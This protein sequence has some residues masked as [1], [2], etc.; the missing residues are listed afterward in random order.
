MA[1]LL[2]YG[3]VGDATDG[4]DAH[5]FCSVIRAQT[6]DL[7]LRINCAGGAVFDGLAIY[8]AIVAYPRRVTVYVDGIAASMASVIAMAAD[9]IIMSD[10]AMMMIHDP[11]TM[12]GGNS[13][14]LRADASK[15]DKVSQ[16]LAGI[17]S[18]RTGLPVSRIAAMMAAETWMTADE[19]RTAGFANRTSPGLRMAAIGN[20]AAFGF[21]HIPDQLRGQ[22]M[23][24]P[25]Q[26]PTPTPG[27]GGPA[28]V[29]QQQFAS[30]SEIR[31]IVAQARLPESVA[32]D[33][34]ERPMPVAEVRAAV[35][36]RIASSAPL[37]SN[38]APT[39]QTFANPEFQAA[40]MAD[41]LYSRMSGK[42]P[43]GAAVAMMNLTMTDMARE[44]LEGAG[45]SGVR[46]MHPNE[47]FN[48]ASFAPR[49]DFGGMHTTSDFPGLLQSAGQRFLLD[50]FVAAE[51]AIKLLS[52]VRNANDFR[53]LTVLKLSGG[54]VLEQTPEAGEI[55]R[56]GFSEGKESYSIATFA[57]I[58]AISRQALINDDLGAFTDPARAMGR[59]SAETEAQQ[60]AGLLNANAGKGATMGDAKPLFDATH[61]NLAAAGGAI[62]IA[63]ASAGRQTMR[64]QLDADG[65]TPLNATAKFLLTGP[66]KETEA[67]QFLTT[68]SATQTANVNPF[69]GKIT[70]LVDPRIAGNAW[71]LFADPAMLPVIEHAYLNGGAGPMMETR[72][73]WDVLGTEFR[74][75][76]DFGCGLVDY[77]G[78]YLNTG[79]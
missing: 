32:L 10:T 78:A 51:S 43:E 11:E 20:L 61:K 34:A 48:R 15:L 2:L 4:L 17:Y 38:F 42:R 73:G 49:A 19:A 64:A 47:V 41:A 54:G 28:I 22:T 68:L 14:A 46:R 57:K 8:E 3:I 7:A 63:T 39:A 67:E 21:R 74:V 24:V 62:T 50:M 25:A 37:I 66:A 31:A 36:D 72:Q 9:E 1:E 59:A 58:F 27:P 44:M 35:I 70:P 52:R 26:T 45:V 29:P 30:V 76:L 60:F 75:V 55:T 33:L 65:V 16:Q 12:T 40:T 13:T 53:A 71:R 18:R 56:V 79:D 23:T 69:P 5:T 77:R 6:D